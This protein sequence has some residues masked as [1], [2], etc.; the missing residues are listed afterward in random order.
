MGSDELTSY[1]ST[2]RGLGSSGVRFSKVAY[3]EAAPIIGLDP[4]KSLKD[5]TTFEIRCSEIPTHL[6]VTDVDM[7]HMMLMQ[8]G[9]PPEHVMEEATSRFF[10]L[11]RII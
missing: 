6:F 8:Y 1:R 2:W 11:V 4:F 9:P 3:A 5:V 10:S 7:N